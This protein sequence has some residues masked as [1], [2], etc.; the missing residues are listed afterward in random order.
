MN[1]AQP[2]HARLSAA[3]ARQPYAMNTFVPTAVPITV[4]MKNCA[5]QLACQRRSRA[6]GRDGEGQEEAVN[7]TDTDTDNET[8]RK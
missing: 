3:F 2:C 6:D 7:D 4:P 1:S 8:K 5:E